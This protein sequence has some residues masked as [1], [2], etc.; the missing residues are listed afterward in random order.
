MAVVERSRF[1]SRL[2]CPYGP[3]ATSSAAL[4]Q[5]LLDLR[6]QA[7][8]VG[9]DY[10]RV[11]PVELPAS[12]KS[13]W[14]MQK[15]H[16]DIHPQHTVINDLSGGDEA[17]IAGTSQTVRRIWRKNIAAG[18]HYETSY[19]PAAI[20]DFLTMLRSVSSR[21]A[22]TPHPDKYFQTMANTL[23]PTHSAGL[24]FAHLDNKRVA[25][26]LFF[27]TPQTVYYAH[28]ASL[29]EYRKSS[30]ATSL[31][32]HALLF[33][34]HED[35]QVFD[36]FGAAGPDTPANHPWQGFTQFKL[37]FGGQL[38]TFAGTWEIPIRTLRYRLYRFLVAVYRKIQ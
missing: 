5:A 8:T 38:A 31:A 4:H 27:K 30:P 6:E 29:S 15:A 1:L 19:D 20:A 13:F 23:F 22:M 32:L 25:G 36:F 14:N 3:F 33:A 10:L 35:A 18:I 9:V 12:E 7:H 17:I 37:S 21:T 26:I 2:Y 34:Y 16:K 11:E 24:L 28:A